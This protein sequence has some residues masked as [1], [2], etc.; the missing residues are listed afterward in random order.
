MKEIYLCSDQ[1]DNSHEKQF[2]L[3]LKPVLQRFNLSLWGRN[4]LVAGTNWK[5]EMKRHLATT[6]FFV[7]LVSSSLLAS[8][9]CIIEI[10]SAQYRAQQEG[11]KIISILLR[12]CVFEYSDLSQ[13]DYLP[14]SGKTI[15]EH[16]NTDKAWTEVQRDFVEM[17]T[18]SQ[19]YLQEQTDG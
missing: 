14:K 17:V 15:I 18:H 5:D 1:Q 6:A 11:L 4:D 8:D 10:L 2:R 9:M 16:S 7:P 12:P 19:R 3:I 13:Y